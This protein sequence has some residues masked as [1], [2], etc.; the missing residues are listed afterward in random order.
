MQKTQKFSLSA[1]ALGVLLA[2]A[3]P[4]HALE[5]T[6][7]SFRDASAG[8]AVVSYGSGLSQSFD[9]DFGTLSSVTLSFVT[10]RNE[11]ASTMDFSA[12]INNLTGLN[13]EGFTVKLTGG[14]TFLS[15]YGTVT[16]GFG[17]IA[18]TTNSAT[19][20]STSFSSGES[21]ALEFGNPLSM[22]GQSDWTISFAGVQAGST[23]GIN[24]TAVPEP[25]TYAMLLAGLG[26]VGSLVRRRRS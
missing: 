1:I 19:Q 5:Y 7:A 13:F 8:N 9:I 22:P 14:A 25:E 18:G 6:G 21:Y 12:L 24:V 3:A 11:G 26:L 4:A 17:T 20:S 23:F 10:F 15:P 2:A 16:P